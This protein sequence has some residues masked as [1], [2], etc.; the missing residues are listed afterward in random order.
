MVQRMCTYPIIAVLLMITTVAFSTQVEA[1]SKKSGVHAVKCGSKKKKGRHASRHTRCN[2]EAGKQQAMDLLK[3]GPADLKALAG[4]DGSD[5]GQDPN[6]GID[7]SV[8]K[9]LLQEVE[10]LSDL[11]SEDDSSIDAEAFK[12]LWMSYLDPDATDDNANALACGILKQPVMNAIMNWVGTR[13]HFGGSSRS[14]IDCSAF[15]RAVFATSANIVLPRTAQSQIEVGERVGA[16]DD[17][18]FGDLVFF[19][20]RNHTYVSHVGIYLGNKLFAHSS[21]RFGV[22][23]SSLES[24]YYSAH[25]IGARR[26]TRND[27]QA[28]ASDNAL[29]ATGTH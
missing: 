21:T 7:V 15:V 5:D 4:V 16:V 6:D 19:H 24:D 13:Y 1:K 18:Q 22:T 27:V 11:Q 8:Q 2:T 26:L 17:L 3:N 9:Q 28:L 25:L 14:G 29:A 10:D 12:M 20:T 23:V